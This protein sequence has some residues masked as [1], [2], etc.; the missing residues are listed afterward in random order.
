M[1]KLL[2]LATVVACLG[3]VACAT[4][5]S[6][7][8]PQSHP[9]AAPTDVAV[10]PSARGDLVLL[11]AF[12]EQDRSY[13]VEGRAAAS[14][15]LEQLEARA[16]SLS[17]VQVALAAARVAALADNGHTM[18]VSGV[19]GPALDR[20][21]YRLALIDGRL[22]IVDPGDDPALM[23]AE[24]MTIDGV[25]V[26][27]IRQAFHAY[28]GGSE[29]WRDQGVAAFVETPAAMAADGV[30]PRADPL[31]MVLMTR[32]GER[33]GRTVAARPSEPAFFFAPG[34][35]QSSGRRSTAPEGGP[36]PLYLRDPDIPFFTT[37]VPELEGLYVAMRAT[38]D[39]ADMSITGFLTAARAEIESIRP[40]NVILDM[41]FNIGGDLNTARD[42]AK[43]LPG[44][45]P[46]EGRVFAI[47][48]GSTFS[49]AISTLGYLKEAGGDRVVIVGEPIGD[50]LEFW[51][52]G[53]TV[54]LPYSGT[55]LLYATERHNYQTGCPEDDCHGSI[56]RNPI[57]VETLRPDLAAPMTIE[58]FMQGRDPAMEA[59][60][61]FLDGRD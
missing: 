10:S 49:A 61:A 23:G 39:Q 26:D 29:P 46:P 17:P 11:R 28:R 5:T 1:R 7:L 52:E 30:I 18:V 32:S 14:A 24:V 38:R 43:A 35:L 57:R 31:A 9:A 37:P 4:Q 2:L 41:R 59:I 19:G 3:T 22:Y 42:F 27:R 34:A 20:I 50:R 56:R 36:Q 54:D 44:L 58:A 51:A 60:A 13:S 40:R 12:V 21:P 25:P 55:M 47:T 8:P 16:G 53:D 6:P 48:S 45:L 15:Q 33:V